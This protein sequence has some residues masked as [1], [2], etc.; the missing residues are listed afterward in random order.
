MVRKK[1]QSLRTLGLCFGFG[2][3]CTVESEKCGFALFV[4][5]NAQFLLCCYDLKK[6]LF[7]E[8]LLFLFLLRLHNWGLWKCQTTHGLIKFS[9]ES[10]GFAKIDKEVPN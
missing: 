5:G 9:G 7:P 10:R 2:C 6:K 8:K 4:G 1:K 3:D